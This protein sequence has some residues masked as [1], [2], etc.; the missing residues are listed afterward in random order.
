MSIPLITHDYETEV[1]KEPLPVVV[2][3][4]ASWCPKCSMMKDVVERLALHHRGTLIF[5]KVDIDLSEKVAQELGVEI[6]PTF[7]IYYH[8][9]ILGYTAGVLSEQILEDR[10]FEMLNPGA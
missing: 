8:G 5:K 6:V 4:F 3:F 9:E 10:I 2:E 1:T 7:V